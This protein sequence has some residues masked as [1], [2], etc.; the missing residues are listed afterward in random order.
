MLAQ[1]ETYAEH[2]GL[3][4]VYCVATN[5]FGPHDCFDER[6]GHVIPAL[7]SKLYTAKTSDCAFEVWGSGTPT[8]DFLYSK[9]AAR[10][11]VL[12]AQRA[13]GVL[14]LATGRSCTIREAV[15][16]LAAVAKFRGDIVWD[17]SKPDGQMQRNY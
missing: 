4:Y 16:V 14:N 8:R 5:M 3:Q 15:E 17:D 7:V 9:D 1:L 6:W 13:D 10:A 2:D 12:A 11:L